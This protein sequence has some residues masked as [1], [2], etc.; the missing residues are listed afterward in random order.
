MST[1]GNILDPTVKDSPCDDVDR[2]LNGSWP[3]TD[4]D[5]LTDCEEFVKGTNRRS[6]DTDQ[7]G[8]PD[9]IELLTGTNPFE[10]EQ[11]KDT[12]FDGTPDWLEVQK[13][14]NVR[15]ND[16]ILR[17]RYSYHYDIENAGLIAIDQGMEEQS[18]VRQYLFNISNIDLV[19]TTIEERPGEVSEL[20]MQPGDNLIRFFIAQTPEDRPDSPPVYR[21]AEVLVNLYDDRRTFDISGSSFELFH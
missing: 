18:F 12:D 21:V 14:T 13:H 6:I 11:S 20:L 10:I 9:S 17:E 19:D 16:P 7:D 3:D 1:P 5:G 15:T 8:I 2:D 4:R